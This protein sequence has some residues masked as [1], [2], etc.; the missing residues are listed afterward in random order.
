MTWTGVDLFFC[1]SGF[2]IGGII[3]DQRNTSNF[4]KVFYARRALRILPL[5]GLSL[6]GYVLLTRSLDG[7]WTYATFTQNLRWAAQGAWGPDWT[8]ITWSLAVEEQFYLVLP[9]LIRLCAPRA[10][11]FVLIG[12]ICTAPVC[13]ALTLEYY[14]NPYA[15][16][17]LFPCRMDALFAGV[18]GAWA[19]RQPR[20]LAQLS[21]P[22]WVRAL[23]LLALWVGFVTLLFGRY[24]VLSPV[25]QGIGYSWIALTYATTLFCIVCYPRSEIIS[26]KYLFLLSYA[27]LGAYAIYLFHCPV[28]VILKNF[29][30]NFVATCCATLLVAV[31]AVA[32]WRLIEEPCMKFGRRRFRYQQPLSNAVG[33][34]S[35]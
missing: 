4:Y 19:L 9:L 29:V 26:K 6:I 12:L 13:R 8:G 17:L 14:G 25:M 28:Q 16:Y 31:L 20:L 1:L 15:A 27:G 5:Y 32:T 30:G 33:A 3:I 34:T 10:L 11:P 24:A 7:M 18:M 21:R 23:A 35:I 2:L 22:G